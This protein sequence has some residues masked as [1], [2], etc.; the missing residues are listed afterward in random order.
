MPATRTSEPSRPVGSLPLDSKEHG[1]EIVDEA[2]D[3]FSGPV[4]DLRRLAIGVCNQLSTRMRSGAHP[5]RVRLRY[6]NPGTPARVLAADV[7]GEERSELTEEEC[8]IWTRATF[9]DGRRDMR[10][11]EADD[12]VG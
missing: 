7:V 1:R 5:S 11:L 2:V 3:L 9:D 6:A 10:L 12:K 8:A 4:H